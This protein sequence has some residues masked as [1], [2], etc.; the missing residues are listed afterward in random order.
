MN[1]INAFDFKNTYCMH[2]YAVQCNVGF[3]L[4]QM[5]T[6][7]QVYNLQYT[8]IFSVHTYMYSRSFNSKN[9]QRP[10]G[11]SNPW[12]RVLYN[13]SAI[14]STVTCFLS[15]RNW[16]GMHS[17]A[18]ENRIWRSLTEQVR[19]INSKDISP[20]IVTVCLINEYRNLLWIMK[21]II[22]TVYL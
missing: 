10:F 12:S 8:L 3:Q 14:H 17:S 19:G 6:A 21:D 11:Y 15:Y 18:G 9:I 4:L 5:H 16:K 1:S 22:H 2:G 7:V 13:V 20:Q